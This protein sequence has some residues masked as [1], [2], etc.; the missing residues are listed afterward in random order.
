MTDGCWVQFWDDDNFLGATL[1]FDSAG[2]ERHVEDLDDYDQSDGKKE[3]NEPDSLMTGSRSW[4]IVYEDDGYEGKTGMFPPNCAIED[5][6]VY[7]LGG[8]ISSFKLYDYRPVGFNDSTMGN[9][10]IVEDDVGE[11]NAQRVNTV[12]RT[13]VAAAVKLIPYAGSA[14]ALLVK[15]LWPDISNRD[16]VWGS[17]QNYLNQVIAGVYWQIKVEGL[18]DKL[19]TLRNAAY[20]VINTPPDSEQERAERFQYLYNLVNEYEQSFIDEDTPE[21]LV[22]Y[23]VPFATLRLV[24]LREN[25]DHYEYYHGNAPSAALREELAGK[26]TSA[27]SSY[28]DLLARARERI[29]SRRLELIGASIDYYYGV[30]YVS[31]EAEY[32][33]GVSNQLALK[34]DL[35]FSMSQL[36]IYLDPQCTDPV[37][38]PVIR[39]T[40]GPFGNP[41]LYESDYPFSQ[42]AEGQ[43]RISNV[44][45]W[46]NYDGLQGLELSFDGVAQGKVGQELGPRSDMPVAADERIIVAYNY[47]GVGCI[48]FTTTH[49]N[50]IVSRPVSGDLQHFEVTVPIPEAI[51]VRLVGISG[52]GREGTRGVTSVSYVWECE[53]TIGPQETPPGDADSET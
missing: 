37:K 21:V 7:G 11:I 12:L 51:S 49:G 43:S 19:I 15:G 14:L 16:Q 5:L 46:G 41:T 42:I 32:R 30:K 48:G 20:D 4:L 13:V 18:N 26:I 9:P 34:I 10:T 1:R 38:P 52:V 22:Q 45:L 3:G 8:N 39:Y 29:L 47:Y 25:L 40:V 31:P 33:Q 28:T 24:V 44:A 36:W 53:L 50:T 27:I 2:A 23:F 6:G 35:A 17:F